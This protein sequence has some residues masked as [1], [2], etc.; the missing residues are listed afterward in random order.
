[1]PKGQEP[2]TKFRVDISELKQNMQAAQREI[3]LANAEFKAATAGMDDWSKSADGLSEKIKQLEKIESSQVK[4]LDLL[5]EQY[6]LVVAE[7]GENSKAA[8]ELEIKIKNQEA[9]VGKTH[10]SLEDF[11]KKLDESEEATE[12]LSQ[13]LDKATDSAEDA[14]GGFTVLK[15]ALADLIADGL[16]AAADAFKDLMVAGDQ[17]MGSFQAKT[18]ASA[19]EMEKFNEQITDLY[20]NNFGEDL[21]DVAD[22]MATVAQ[23][24][25]EVDPTKIRDLTENALTLRDTFGWEVNETMRAANML[26]DQF[27]ISGDEAFALIAQGAQNGLD[28]NGD[29]LDSINEYSVHYK[30]MGLTAEEFFNSLQNGTESGTFSV[31][32]LGDAMKEFGIRVKDG[33]KAT[34]QALDAI[35]L[36]WEAVETAFSRGGEDAREELYW[37]TSLLFEME[38]PLERN[39][40][41]VALFGTMWEDLGEEGIKALTNING[42][43]DQTADVMNRIK[44]AK[45]ADIGSQMSEIGRIIKMD[46]LTPL[47]EKVLPVVKEVLTLA[48]DNI[49]IVTASIV[50]LTSAFVAFKAAAAISGVIDSFTKFKAAQEGATVA[51][52]LLNAAMSANPVGLIV[53]AITGL[54]AAFVLLWN[55]S[56]EFREFWIDLWEKIKEGF[57]KA[58]DKVKEF[59]DKTL[60]ELFAK[61]YEKFEEF[62]VTAKKF[63]DNVLKFFK[64]LPTG[65]YNVIVSILGHIVAWGV[66]LVE[67]ARNDVPK[68]INNVIEWFS[69]LPSRIWQWL[70]NAWNKT[71]EWGTNMVAT[72][73]EKASAFVEGA[74]TFIKNLPSKVAEWLTATIQKIIQWG[75]DMITK[76]KQAARDTVTG[77]VDAFFGLPDKLYNVGSNALQGFWNG[78]K[79]VASS[80]KK[81]ATNFFNDIL[82]KAEEVLDI[83]SPSRAFRQIAEYTMEGFDIGLTSGAKSVMANVSDTFS[84]VRNRASEALGG[85]SGGSGGVGVNSSVGGLNNG[86][87]VVYNF[88]QTNNS[89]KALSRYEIYRQSKNLLNRGRVYV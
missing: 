17:A 86:S 9:A 85:L 16:R 55:T 33:S 25:K 65:I 39:A 81:W 62:K 75:S 1:M 57:F 24:T 45:Y 14:E 8:E 2:T 53:A 28:K 20:K 82:K 4:Q 60:P 71:V 77:V 67:F 27:G 79:S 63:I 83:H 36:D 87:Q 37:I 10:K 30:Q 7:Q 70:L 72:G 66:K 54:V 12:D 13:A 34:H 46:L 73:K 35:G 51:Q 59:F 42:A 38:D 44:E 80:I 40:A 48:K 19:A 18:G 32:K 74:I 78:L 41:G 5:R 58:M 43:A 26:M 22:A 76:G 21:N 47:A 88:T 56:D 89:P 15:G 49:P 6:K 31:D 61:A 64:Q 84:N 3:R 69:T 50:G 29:L 11:R 23:N 68:F 52:W